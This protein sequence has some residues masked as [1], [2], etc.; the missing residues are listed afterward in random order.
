MDLRRSLAFVYLYLIY[1][2]FTSNM[3]F[4]SKPRKV[5]PKGTVRELKLVHSVNRR[6]AHVI[7]TEE[8]EKPKQAGPSESQHSRSA[9]PIKR[10]K[11][12]ATDGAP[13]AVDLEGPDMTNKRQTLVFIHLSR[14]HSR[15]LI[16]SRA[17]MTI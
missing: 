17:K 8:T 14:S 11:L 2:S 9:S 1:I 15:C 13:I 16:I 3:S 7:T 12:E 10:Q 6:G 5:K 4:A